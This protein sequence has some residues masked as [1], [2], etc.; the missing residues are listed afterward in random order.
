MGFPDPD[1]GSAGGVGQHSPVPVLL[2]GLSAIVF[3]LGD[4][5]GGVAIRRADRR[6][7]PIA[8]AMVASTVGAVAIG[9]VLLVRPPEAVAFADVA[10]PVAAGLMMAATRPLLYLG[11]ARGPVA[12]FAPGFG[13]TLI[14]VPA[15]VGPFIGQDPQPV[16]VLGMLLAVPA[17]VFLSGEG[18]LPSVGEFVRSPVIGLAV[19]VGTSIGM[20]GVFL[21]QPAPESGELPAFLVVATGAVVLPLAARAQGGLRW[22]ER[23]VR[24]YGAV[25]GISSATAFVLS[26]AAY[27][28]GSAAVVTAMIAMAPAVSVLVSWRFLGERLY[29]IQ[30]VG[31]LFGVAAVVCFALGV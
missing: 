22:P 17:V 7:A 29:R 11:M 1:G 30:A 12:V 15:I 16:E 31:G 10:W 24:R 9:V 6:G 28:R 3:G 25:L 18:R 23:V 13:L 2:A 14:V 26:T 20:A 5:L 8:V 19:L 4:L 27:L 21:T